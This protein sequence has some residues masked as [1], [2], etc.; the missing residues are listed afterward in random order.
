MLSIR[1]SAVSVVA[2]LYIVFKVYI[3][4]A[5]FVTLGAPPPF[6]RVV[7]LGGL[8]YLLFLT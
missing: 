1:G 2:F 5:N 7:V 8:P 6:R 3:L 4:I